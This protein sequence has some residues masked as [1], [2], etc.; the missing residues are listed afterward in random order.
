MSNNPSS[1]SSEPLL[2]RNNTNTNRADPYR[3]IEPTT[4]TNKQQHHYHHSKGHIKKKNREFIMSDVFEAYEEEF[5][6]SLGE[7]KAVLN[8]LAKTSTTS[9]D[10]ESRRRKLE[11]VEPQ[12]SEAESLIRQMEVEVRGLSGE[13]KN[14]LNPVLQGYKNTMKATRD[15]FLAA[16]SREEK[17]MLLGGKFCFFFFLSFLFRFVFKIFGEI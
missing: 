7:V 8:E 4:T 10:T 9:Q 1:E 13:I 2:Y 16:L 15:D 3:D 12:L 14:K 11:D 6:H 5:E 17:T